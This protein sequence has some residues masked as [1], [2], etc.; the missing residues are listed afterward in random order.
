MSRPDL[1]I[2]DIHL[3]AVACGAHFNSSVRWR[4]ALQ[5]IPS[6]RKVPRDWCGYVWDDE[7]SVFLRADAN[8]TIRISND[9]EIPR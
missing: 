4:P 5:S 3:L 1:D 2:A 9:F 7:R 8:F 6:C